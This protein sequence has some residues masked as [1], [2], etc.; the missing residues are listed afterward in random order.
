MECGKCHAELTVDAAYCARCGAPVGGSSVLDPTEHRQAVALAAFEHGRDPR[1]LECP[2]CGRRSLRVLRMD[3]DGT[4]VFGA[5][6]LLFGVAALVLVA[7]VGD[8]GLLVA[9]ASTVAA[10]LVVAGV[11]LLLL[12]RY[13]RRPKAFECTA[14]GSRV[15]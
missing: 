7:L 13:R 2:K 11:L 15:P 14:C 9:N 6:A 4:M 10:V 12:A 1:G 3:A 8:S 5:V